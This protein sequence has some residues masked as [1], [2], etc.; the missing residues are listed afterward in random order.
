MD[1]RGCGIELTLGLD[2]RAW[3]AATRASVDYL[4]NVIGV[5]NLLLPPFNIQFHEHVL[6]TLKGRISILSTS[7][8]PPRLQN[9]ACEGMGL[10]T[11]ETAIYLLLR[12]L[13]KSE[14]YHIL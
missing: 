8:G 6:E 3:K 13:F 4:G 10:I 14:Y 7:Q 5:E 11:K 2:R 1:L 12:E 9:W